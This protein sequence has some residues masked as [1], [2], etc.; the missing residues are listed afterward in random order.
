[1]MMIMIM[2]TKRICKALRIE[3]VSQFLYLRS[4]DYDNNVTF[5]SSL[6]GEIKILNIGICYKLKLNGY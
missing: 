4:I 1:M 6:I 2:K 5:L 3:M